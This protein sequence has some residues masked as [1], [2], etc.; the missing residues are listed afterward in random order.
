M[1]RK[2]IVNLSFIF[3]LSS[4]SCGAIGPQRKEFRLRNSP[5]QED[6]LGLS[7]PTTGGKWPFPEGA[8]WFHFN[9]SLGIIGYPT[10]G[11]RRAFLP[12][13]A[14]LDYGITPHLSVGPYLG[15]YTIRITDNYKGEQYDS[16]LRSFIMG[17][18]LTFHGT[19]VLNEHLGAHIDVKQWDIYSALSVGVVT[20]S[21]SVDD[22]YSDSRSDYGVSIYPSTSLILGARYFIT[23]GFAIHA[24]TGKGSFGFLSFGISARIL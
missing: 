21:W 11:T 12:F 14:C 15:V 4:L 10:F 9:T 19:D 8:L 23:P 7:L 17:G 6:L 2:F 3:L 13:Q 24:E 5:F 1:H 16:K 18:R 20:R 22:K